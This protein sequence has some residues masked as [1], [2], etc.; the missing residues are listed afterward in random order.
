MHQSSYGSGDVR[1]QLGGSLRSHVGHDGSSPLIA[2]AHYIES[3]PESDDRLRAL[4]RA[5]AWQPDGLPIE[6]IEPILSG[7]EN[8]NPTFPTV[9]AMEG[10]L[11][12]IVGAIVEAETDRG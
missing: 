4:S 11:N 10:L 1:G 8:Q 3:L 9:D 12:Q 6:L 2:T 5:S 7:F